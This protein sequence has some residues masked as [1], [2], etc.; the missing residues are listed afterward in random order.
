MPWFA[1]LFGRDSL[2]T[3]FETLSFVPGMAER[4]CGCWRGGWARSTTTSATRSPARCCT[5]CASASRRR[6]GETPFAR[7][8]GSVDATPLFLCLLGHYADWSGHLDLFREL[9]GPAE[10]A[11]EWI[12]R[13]GDLDGDGLVEYQRR[14]THG[15]ET[16]GWKD[17]FGRDPRRRRRAAR[18]R[19]SRS[20]RCR[21]T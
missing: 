9:R 12:D 6:S 16:Q 14:S 3:A 5:S 1:T 13:Y 17:S 15:L 11:L 7:Y 10:A 4:R 18:A 21:A 19:P 20:W 8:Y 2:I